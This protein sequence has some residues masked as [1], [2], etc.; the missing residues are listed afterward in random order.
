VVPVPNDAKRH[1]WYLS[2]M[3]PVPDDAKRHKWYLSQ[4]MPKQKRKDKRKCLI[5]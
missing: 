4:M 3:M 5:K 1:K 2:Q